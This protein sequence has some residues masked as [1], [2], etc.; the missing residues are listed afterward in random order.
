M[1]YPPCI[2]KLNDKVKDTCE[3][4]SG[5]VRVKETYRQLDQQI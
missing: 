4:K 3:A 5:R 1:Q 2:T